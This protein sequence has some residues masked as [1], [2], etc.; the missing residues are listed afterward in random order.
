MDWKS[1]EKLIEET[2]LQLRNFDVTI[3]TPSELKHKANPNL[4]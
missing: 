2:L 4:S 1:V 3:I